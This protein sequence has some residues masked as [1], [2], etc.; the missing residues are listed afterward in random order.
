MDSALIELKQAL[1]DLE[2]TIETLSSCAEEIQ[3]RITTLH[4][5]RGNL[6]R[7]IIR[8][9]GVPTPTTPAHG[10]EE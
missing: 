8:L 4:A 5:K 2:A 10:G 6:Q 1:A 3:R 7:S 9:I